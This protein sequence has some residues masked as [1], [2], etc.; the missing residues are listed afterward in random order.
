M[1]Y[2]DL[3]IKKRVYESKKARDVLD[4][5]FTEFTLKNRNVQE[6]FSVYNSKFYELLS[7]THAFFIENSLSYHTTWANP[8]IITI[9]GLLYQINAVK[10]NINSFEKNHPIIPNGLVLC[11]YPYSFD[12][13]ST[14][15]NGGYVYLVQTSKLRKIKSIDAYEEIKSRSG[16]IG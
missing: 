4:E 2:L 9:N 12:N 14:L 3:N 5:E 11:T 7:D 6:F 10:Y 8:R 13:T 16:I 1:P 15:I